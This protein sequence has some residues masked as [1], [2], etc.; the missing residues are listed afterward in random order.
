MNYFSELC[1]AHFPSNQSPFNISEAAAANE[2]A[3]AW[4]Q[5]AFSSDS[6][7]I[8]ARMPFHVSS[9]LEVSAGGATYTAP[10]IPKATVNGVDYHTITV[11]LSSF[12]GQT[13]QLRAAVVDPTVTGAP[14]FFES[15]PIEVVDPSDDCAKFYRELRYAAP[16]VGFG[17]FFGAGDPPAL[18]VAFRINARLQFSGLEEE[19]R[20]ELLSA[21]LSS[22]V[23]HTRGAALYDLF[24]EYAPLWFIKRVRY[25]T[26][27]PFVWIDGA[28]MVQASPL[29]RGPRESQPQAL[30]Q[31]DMQLKAAQAVAVYPG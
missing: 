7:I 12:A 3:P 6:L 13:I 27:L 30:Y 1:T 28:R 29:R 11:P 10:T 18:S 8:Q 31:S 26:A 14:Q 21:G 23:P 2:F 24:L 15:W 16:L 5:L 19:G 9:G 17:H 25:A 4:S 22:I 20:E